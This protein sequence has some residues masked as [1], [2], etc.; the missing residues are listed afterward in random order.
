VAK[1]YLEGELA[2]YD[3]WNHADGNIRVIFSSN[4]QFQQCKRD[5]VG[6]EVIKKFLGGSWKEWII[7]DALN[8]IKAVQDDEI[9]RDAI[10]ELPS[11][12]HSKIFKQGVKRHKLTKKEQ[13][14][15]AEHIQ[16]Q[17][18][19]KREMAFTINKFVEASRPK[20]K[21][22]EIPTPPK[23]PTLDEYVNEVIGMAYNL[24]GKLA[25]IVPHLDNMEFVLTEKRFF[26]ALKFLHKVIGD[27]LDRKSTKNIKMLK[28]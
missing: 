28:P 19:S 14:A 16:E 9:S 12:Q 4:S 10:N 6:R 7:Q 8:T 17:Q 25:P 13:D 3:S 23:L 22:T 18:P 15:L 21:Q 11:T 26:G 1:E 5:G 20:P 24:E 27:I 2:K